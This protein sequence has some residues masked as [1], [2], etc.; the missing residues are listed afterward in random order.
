MNV[1][2][3]KTRGFERKG[4]TVLVAGSKRKISAIKATLVG[5]IANILITDQYTAQELLK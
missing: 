5:E 2:R 1:S 3:N 4:K